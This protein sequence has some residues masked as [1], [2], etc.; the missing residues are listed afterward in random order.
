MFSSILARSTKRVIRRGFLW[1]IESL[2]CAL[3]KTCCSKVASSDEGP[4]RLYN[5]Y[6]ER[7]VLKPD[8]CQLQVVYQLQGLYERLKDYDPRLQQTSK[9]GILLIKCFHILCPFE[10]YRAAKA[11]FNTLGNFKISTLPLHFLAHSPMGI[12]SKNASFRGFLV[13]LWL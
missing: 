5:S 9:S 8:D 10:L 6:L 3:R 4:L 1:D 2:S 7:Q 13:T 11:L 12:L